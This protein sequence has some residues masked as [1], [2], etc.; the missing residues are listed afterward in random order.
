MVDT[1]SERFQVVIAGAGVAALETMIALR[2]LAGPRVDITLVAPESEFVYRPL[3]VAAP[4]GLD[5]PPSYP[6]GPIV[7]D[8]GATH[9]RD[10]LSW[11]AAGSQRVFLES[12]DELG[13]D[14]L[15]VA[16]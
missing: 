16:L 5:S 10:R 2:A 15:V 1:K 11:V 6:L 8:F 3:A 12:G 14:A 9:R 13:Y 7:A 4:F